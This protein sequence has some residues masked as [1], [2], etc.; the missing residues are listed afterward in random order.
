M[1]NE[2]TKDKYFNEMFDMLGN[3]AFYIEEANK[4]YDPFPQELMMYRER[5]TDLLKKIEN[6]D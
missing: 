4:L 3:V 5:I 2:A 1:M 6:E